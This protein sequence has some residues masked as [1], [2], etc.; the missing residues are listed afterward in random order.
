VLGWQDYDAWWL[1][2][3]TG[4][5]LAGLVLAEQGKHAVHG[6]LAVPLD[7]GVPQTVAALAGPHGYTLHEASRGALPGSTTNCWRS[8]PIANSRLACRWKP[9]YTGKALL[10][11]RDQVGPGA[12]RPAPA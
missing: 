6:A 4:T 7:H 5:T 3:G 9:L 12:S 8:S 10:A 2:A 11:L 1:A